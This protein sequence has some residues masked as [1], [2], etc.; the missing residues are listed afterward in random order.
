MPTKGQL[1]A[2]STLSVRD[3]SKAGRGGADKAGQMD[4]NKV[5]SLTPDN[6]GPIYIE[7]RSRPPRTGKNAFGSVYRGIDLCKEGKKL[8]EKRLIAYISSLRKCLSL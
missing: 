3:A 5:A 4:Y 7:L 6:I 8:L 2:V 1:P